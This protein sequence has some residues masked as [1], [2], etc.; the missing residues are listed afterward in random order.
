MSIKL[1]RK[2]LRS[3]ADW[4][5]KA[6]DNAVALAKRESKQKRKRQEDKDKGEP[7]TDQDML[8]HHVKSMLAVDHSIAHRRSLDGIKKE[9]KRKKAKLSIVGN[10]SRGSAAQNAVVQEPTF[11]KKRHARE[12]KESTLKKIAQLLKKTTKKKVLSSM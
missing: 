10:N 12:E 11:S 7:V 4:E 2:F 1:V 9:S 6:D 8:R 5:K 3:T